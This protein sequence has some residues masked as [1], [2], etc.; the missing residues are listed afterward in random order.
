[1]AG[2]YANQILVPDVEHAVPIETVIDNLRRDIEGDCTALLRRARTISAAT[3]GNGPFRLK[4]WETRINQLR[5]AR[6]KTFSIQELKGLRR[7][8]QV[9]SQEM[10]QFTKGLY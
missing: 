4:F 6:A 5:E 10:E 1:M 8:C 9:L 2:R 3:H 7:Q